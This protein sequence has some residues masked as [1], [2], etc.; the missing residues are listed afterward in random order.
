MILQFHFW[1]YIQKSCKQSLKRYLCTK[2]TEALVPASKRWKQPKCLSTDD[3]INKIWYIHRLEYYSAP[4]RKWNPVTYYNMGEPWGYYAKWNEP[5]TRR[6]TLHNS[7]Y[8]RYLK[9]N[10]K[11][12]TEERGLAG[13]GGRGKG[14]LWLNGYK[15]SV[16]QSDVVVEIAPE[17][18][19]CRPGWTRPTL[20]WREPLTLMRGQTDGE[21][22][23]GKGKAALAVNDF[24]FHFS[25][26][27][28]RIPI[29]T[30]KRRCENES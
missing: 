10:L 7:T 18:A 8:M 1:V 16:W 21:G 28:G 30:F 29:S 4:E 9:S 17:G 27:N 14:E 25:H 11:K 24:C 3:W 26:I 2:F 13:P 5:V 23:E 20:R 22:D 6:Q 12:R 15:G 19:A